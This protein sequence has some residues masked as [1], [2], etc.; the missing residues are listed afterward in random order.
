MTGP[1]PTPFRPVGRRSTCGRHAHGVAVWLS[2]VALL[3]VPAS[4]ASCPNVSI[5]QRGALDF[6]V[7]RVQPGTSGWAVLSGGGGLVTSPGIARASGRPAMPGVIRLRA[8]PNSELTLALSNPPTGPGAEPFKFENI[9]H[10][11]QGARL[12]K[13]GDFWVLRTRPS[14]NLKVEVILEMGAEISVLPVSTPRQ[15][16]TRIGIECVSVRPV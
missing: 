8:P 15:I 13:N 9:S 14:D 3:W 6:G 5:E 12:T 4:W 11:V 16:T 1:H 2:L 10:N 7:L